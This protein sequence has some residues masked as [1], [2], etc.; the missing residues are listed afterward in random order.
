MMLATRF[1]SHYASPLAGVSDES[2]ERFVYAMNVQ[3]IDAV[4]ASGGYGCFAMRPRRLAELDVMVNLR[5]VRTT[6]GRQVQDGDFVL[7]YSKDRF[8]GSP[9]LQYKIF[10]KSILAYDAAIEHGDIE[11]P[12]GIGHSEALAILHVGGHG[13]IKSWP[14]MFENTAAL[15]ERIKGAF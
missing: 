5:S 4:S 1:K 14:K 9:S 13:A 10:E 11:V 8:L 12:D 6:E 15:V 3:P 2:W 7:P